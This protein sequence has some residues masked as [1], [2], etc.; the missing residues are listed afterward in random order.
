MWG[1]LYKQ[2]FNEDYSSLPQGS[3]SFKFKT[4]NKAEE[5]LFKVEDEMYNLDFEIGA[6]RREM[7]KLQEEATKLE[8]MPEDQRPLYKVSQ[9]RF[10]H[11][12]KRQIGKAY[13]DMAERIYVQLFSKSY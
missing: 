10:S 3:E 1:P 13:Q 9:T 7:D 8:K 2:V 6:L 11:L 12:M 4:K 5:D